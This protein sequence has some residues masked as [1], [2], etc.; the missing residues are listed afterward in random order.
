MN[1]DSIG[2]R[3]IINPTGT[4]GTSSLVRPVNAAGQTVAFNNNATVAY[5]VVNPNAQYI[6]A[7][8]GARAD[9]GRNTLRTRGFNRTDA[10]LIKNFRFGERFNVQAGLETLNLFNSRIRTL[11]GL[12]TQSGVAA[13]A[14]ATAGNLNFNDYSTGNYEGRTV[15]LRAKFIF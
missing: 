13:S 3:T 9:A 2:D 14:F 1:F 11:A 4:P 8:Q 12:G 10:T 15:Q 6:Q 7:G 5:V